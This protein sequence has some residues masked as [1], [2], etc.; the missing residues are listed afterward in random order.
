MKDQPTSNYSTLWGYKPFLFT[1]IAMLIILVI[2]ISIV[3]INSWSQLTFV[4]DYKGINFLFTTIMK[5]PGIILLIGSGILTF[6]A[7]T[8]RSKQAKDQLDALIIQNNFSN[9]YKHKEEF[10]KYIK[11]N[12]SSQF[13]KVDIYILH[14][15]I[16]PNMR[17]KGLDPNWDIVNNLKS[18]LKQLKN[19]IAIFDLH[20]NQG[21]KHVYDDYLDIQ[22]STKGLSIKFFPRIP[23]RGTSDQ[24]KTKQAMIEACELFILIYKFE[25][26]YQNFLHELFNIRD[27]VLLYNQGRA[28]NL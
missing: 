20:D 22:L 25:P 21:L 11:E 6:I 8:F 7:T 2:T 16:F 9:Y 14:D 12:F 4:P 18:I 15:H 13:L 24:D 1:F 26:I 27:N 28:N 23:G 10:E 3:F 17:S 19:K 5:G